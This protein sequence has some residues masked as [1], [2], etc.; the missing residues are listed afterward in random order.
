M[1][2]KFG[3]AGLTKEEMY[4]SI[5]GDYSR[6]RTLG[7][8]FCINEHKDESGKQIQPRSEG[9]FDGKIW[10]KTPKG[11]IT[12]MRL[13]YKKQMIKQKTCLIGGKQNETTKNT[14]YAGLTDVSIGKSSAY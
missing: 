12:T 4:C 13:K 14:V 1:E 3:Q 7:E 10:S 9:L 6:A 8:F 11:K 5:C 2:K